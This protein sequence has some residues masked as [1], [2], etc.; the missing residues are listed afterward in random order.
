[1]WAVVSLLNPHAF[2]WAARYEYPWAEFVAIPTLAGFLFFTRGW[3]RILNR[4]VILMVILWAWFTFT[5]VNNSRQ[6]EFVHF[7]PDTWRMWEQV[8]KIL[9][10]TI[11]TIV[12]VNTWERFRVL[13]LVIAG[14]FA[15]LVLKAVPFM[16]VTAGSFRLYGPP[17]SMLADNN[18]FGLALNMTLPIFFALWRVDPNPKVRRIMGITFLAT[19]PAILFTYSRGAL[20]GMGVVMLIMLMRV[21]Q[22]VILIP[23]LIIGATFGVFFAPAKWQQRMDFS[24]QGALIDDSALSRF[25][26]WTYCWRMTMDHPLT[27]AGFEAFTPPLYYR[28]APNPKDVHGPHSIY[29]GVLAEHG[30]PGLFLYLALLGSC[31]WTLWRVRRQALF[32]Q[33]KTAAGYATML[34]MGLVGFMVSGAF[35]GRAYFDYYFMFVACTVILSHAWGFEGTAAP[36]EEPIGEA[37]FA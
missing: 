35:L 26:A 1:M 19:V 33:D 21:P 12:V 23:V 27:G 16:I 28:Y 31:F 20:I 36:V 15:I 2:I 10:M 32:W 8:S 6:P 17:G 30:F 34:Q 11:I 14:C 9:L 22:R 4:E 5:T 24:R 18:D 37:Q 13:L 3:S 25:N 29:F 7:A